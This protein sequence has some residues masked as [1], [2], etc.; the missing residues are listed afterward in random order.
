MSEEKAGGTGTCPFCRTNGIGVEFEKEDFPFHRCGDCGVVFIGGAAPAPSESLYGE[1]YYRWLEGNEAL[2]RGVK[3][4]TFDRWL[5]R[6]ERHASPGRLL[7]IGASLGFGLEAAAA[8]GWRPVGVEVSDFARERALAEKRGAAVYKSLGDIEPGGGAFQAATLF[9]VVEHLY[10]VDEVLR[11]IHG[12]LA[13]GGI[14]ALTTP[15]VESWLAR[16]MGSSWFHVK[17]LEHPFLFSPR[18]LARLLRKHGFEPLEAGPAV[19]SMTLDYVAAHFETYG[20][21]GRGLIG[22]LAALAGASVR[23]LAFP[24]YSGEMLVLARK[25]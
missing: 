5:G 22:L 6:V 17:P 12:L 13:P 4:R 1:R 15:N 14:I 21:P 25:A 8:R 9:D 18:A 2:A 19:K 20:Y 11:A 23:R 16:A 24:V 10:D 3:L 7:D